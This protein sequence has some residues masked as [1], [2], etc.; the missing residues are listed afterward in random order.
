MTIDENAFATEM[1]EQK[2]RGRDAARKKD[3]IPTEQLSWLQKQQA[4]LFV[5]FESLSV[6]ETHVVALLDKEGHEQKQLDKGQWGGIVL[7]QTPFYAERGGQLSDS[8][9]ILRQDGTTVMDVTGVHAVACPC[10]S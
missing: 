5:G 10:A 8:G 9:S 1:A 2:K 6:K 3:S 7:A 4:S